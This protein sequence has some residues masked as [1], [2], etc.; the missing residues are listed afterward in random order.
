MR[1]L[2]LFGEYELTIDEKNRLLIPSEIRK[3]LDPER[4]G[5]SISVVR[6]MPPK[7]GKI[8]SLRESEGLGT[9]PWGGDL[10]E[11]ALLLGG[12]CYPHLRACRW[13]ARQRHDSWGCDQ[14]FVRYSLRC[15]EAFGG[16]GHL[17][18]WRIRT[19]QWAYNF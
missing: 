9:P 10:E 1:P 7:N 17:V 15:C 3:Q 11:R 4:I 8:R 19:K 13:A 2:L 5:M 12:G 6:C 16:F 18:R 14:G